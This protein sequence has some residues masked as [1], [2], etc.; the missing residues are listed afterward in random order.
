MIKRVLVGLLFFVLVRP[1]LPAQ[2]TPVT[3]V[4]C[5]IYT[6][7]KQGELDSGFVQ[8]AGGRITAVLDRT[9]PEQVR[10]QVIDLHGGYL[11]PGLVDAHSGLGLQYPAHPIAPNHSVLEY[12]HPTPQAISGALRNGITTIALRPPADSLFGG[13]SA[14]IHLVPD[15][16]GGPIIAVDT[17]DY[18]IS[19]AGPPVLPEKGITP[20]PIRREQRMYRFR[21]VLQ[22]MN[23]Y[24]NQRDLSLAVRT[25]SHISHTDL[26]LYILVDSG[27]N[28]LQARDLLDT[29]HLHGYYGRLRG[30]VGV[31]DLIGAR[32]VQQWLPS[33]ILGPSLFSFSAEYDRY[34]SI[35]SRLSE[36]G[37]GYAVASF[38]P[39]AGE[40]SLL[41][42]IRQLL[43]YG[44]SEW[45]A[46]ASVTRWP[47][48]Y[49]H[50]DE[51]FGVIEAGAW[52]NL[53]VFD[54]PPLDVTSR[55]ILTVTNGHLLWNV[56]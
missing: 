51:R 56:K 22:T 29:Y 4:N 46:L 3:F 7:T 35:P 32:A 15:S 43:Q 30:I 14:L 41:D 26:P 50:R 8:I 38:Y 24:D 53:V 42:Q 25:L 45:Q 12:F 37:L 19:L 23:D 27:V 49:L 17:L 52:A 48:Q 5:R 20:L 10:G 44:V 1:N 28:L 36:V 16:V 47:G 11:M 34:I 18:Q 54:K 21:N 33:A 9:P 2:P 40:G 6:M 39:V 55:T 31:L 13:Y